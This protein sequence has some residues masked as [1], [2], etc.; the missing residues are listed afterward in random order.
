MKKYILTIE[1]N[2]DTDE[3]EYLTEEII[4]ESPTFYLDDIILNEYLDEDTLELLKD[5]YII[6]ES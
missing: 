6:G 3:V 5:V 2:E 4:E 1:Y